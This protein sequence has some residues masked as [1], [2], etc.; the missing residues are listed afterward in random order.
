MSLGL[1]VTAEQKPYALELSNNEISTH[2]SMIAEY[3]DEL[4]DSTVQSNQFHKPDLSLISQQ[5]EL[6]EDLRTPLLE[7]LFRVAVKTK[8]TNGIFIYAIK[9][10]DRYCSKRIV[11]RNQIQLVLLT[12]L[13]LSAKTLGGC[14]HIINNTNVPTGGRFFGP[15][16]RAR[17][18]RLAELVQLTSTSSNFDQG[19]FVQ[20]ERHILNTLNWDLTDAELQDWV[21]TSEE[22]NYMQMEETSLEFDIIVLKNFLMD[23][24]MF[25]LGFIELQPWEVASLIY[26]ILECFFNFKL[27]FQSNLNIPERVL[28]SEGSIKLQNM[29]ISKILQLV[30]GES[31]IV[32]H[33]TDKHTDIISKFINF[34]LLSVNPPAPT[35]KDSYPISPLDS[36]TSMKNGSSTP[37][38][39]YI[40]HSA[41]VLDLSHQCNYFNYHQFLPYTPPSS[42]RGSPVG[43][44]HNHSYTRT[45]S[46]KI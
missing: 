9:L 2:Y 44:T 24:S 41:S 10:F 31:A 43:M 13:W 16:P 46:F 39:Q 21:L 42:R 30:S 38:A 6:E 25:E 28:F 17:I 37:Q 40:H 12:C 8:V 7:Y 1:R 11:L 22:M 3:Q 5:P 26:Q 29:F 36:P 4:T 32:Q 35:Y 18:P 14:N 27:Q 34:L 23:V 33:Y 45:S 15:N 20:M 19:M